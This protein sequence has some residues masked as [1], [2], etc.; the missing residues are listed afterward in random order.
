MVASECAAFEHKPKIV[1]I[2]FDHRA[3]TIRVDAGRVAFVE[4]CEADAIEACEA[5]ERG[6]PEIPVIGLGDA[7]DYILRKAVFHRPSLDAVL[8]CKCY[9]GHNR[10]RQQRDAESKDPMVM[11]GRKHGARIEI[12]QRV[13]GWEQL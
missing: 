3:E 11:R 2:I 12:M 1:I 7:P 5:V 8:R 4:H 10:D 9:P 6:D 13:N